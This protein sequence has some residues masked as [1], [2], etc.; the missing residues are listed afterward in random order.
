MFD[1]VLLTRYHRDS[2]GEQS[3]TFTYLYDHKSEALWSPT[4]APTR[5]VGEKV[6][7]VFGD[8]K[9]RF[10]KRVGGI[11]TMLEVSVAQNEHEFAPK[12]Q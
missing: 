4:Y 2:L 3:G 1:D 10:F 7:T 9:V 11:A 5:I 6:K 12:L 8:E